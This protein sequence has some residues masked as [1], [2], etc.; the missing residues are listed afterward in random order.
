MIID[1]VYRQGTVVTGLDGAVHDL[2]GITMKQ[3]YENGW[4]NPTNSY[5]YYQNTHSWANGIREASMFTSSWVS[6]QQVTLTYDLSSKVASKVK[7]NG[8]RVSLVGNNLMYLYNSAKDH[9]NPE[10]LNSTGSDAMTE[11]SAMPYIRSFGFSING[12]F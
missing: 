6:L 9:V 2:S 8:L 5:S 11:G 3:A 4:I 12:S 7:M 10:N 1:G